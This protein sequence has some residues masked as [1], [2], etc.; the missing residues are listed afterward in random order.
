MKTPRKTSPKF[1]ISGKKFGRLTAIMYM[2]KSRWK[3][4]CECGRENSATYTNLTQGIVQSC[5]C[6]R[7]EQVRAR[8]TKHGHSRIGHRSKEYSAWNKMKDRCHR[9]T[10]K[11]YSRYGAKGIRVC[12]E[13]LHDF[14]KFLAHIGPCPDTKMS[15]DRIENSKGYEPGNVRWATRKVQSANRT[16]CR[17]LEH[18]GKKMTIAEWADSIGMKREKLYQRINYGLSVGEALK[19][20][21]RRSI[22]RKEQLCH[23]G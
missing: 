7:I 21:D 9:V 18:D 17:Y 3:C 22:P 23:I 14:P 6:F 15:I 16:N 1:D 11:N 4:R 13:W 5:G 12:D 20:T 10:D 19:N 8:L 2:R